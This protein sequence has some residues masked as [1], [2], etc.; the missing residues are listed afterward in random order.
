VPSIVVG[1]GAFDHSF[2][3]N[4]SHK[5]ISPSKF[6]VTKHTETVD[7]QLTMVDPAPATPEALK[8]PIKP[9]TW[10]KVLELGYSGADGSTAAS[11]TSSSSAPPACCFRC[12]SEAASDTTK[13]RPLMKC[14]KCKVAA[15]C[16]KECQIA[17]WK[18]G[19]HKAACASYARLASSA[20]GSTATLPQLQ[21]EDDRRAARD[22]VFGRVRF[23]ACPYAVH[24]LGQLGRGFLFVQS[25]RT[26][27]CLSLAQPKDCSGRPT[28][29][30]SV[31]IHY[32]T[33]GEY[34]QEVTRDDFEMAT[35]R[36]ELQQAV[37][38]YEEQS[39]V[40]V[41]MRFR[42][43]H[44]ALGISPLCSDFALCKQLGQS[45]FAESNAG[46][47]QLNLDDL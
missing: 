29:M 45:Y 30:R 14:S 38:S 6:V 20:T 26:L 7:E 1:G 21:S 43:G 37:N 10:I 12:G 47:L 15:Y 33:L 8:T 28:G 22:E 17:D 36:S 39:E 46:A 11:P 9:L 27:A 4:H 19:G 40:V 13:S 42:C 35:V 2:V 5:K 41:L 23:Y 34:D 18:E 44:V 16:N 24:K 32:L 31:L 25:D 3:S